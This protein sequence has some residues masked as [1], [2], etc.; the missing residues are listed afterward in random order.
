MR[1]TQSEFGLLLLYDKSISRLEKKDID[2]KMNK[3]YT[4]R[5]QYFLGIALFLLLV[6]PFISE[7]KR[8]VR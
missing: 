7:R 4:E 3:Q 8:F 5:F 1:A 6:E 2:A